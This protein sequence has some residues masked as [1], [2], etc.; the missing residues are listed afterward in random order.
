MRY[1][2]SKNE[3][4]IFW[5]GIIVGY[6]EDKEEERFHKRHIFKVLDESRKVYKVTINTRSNIRKRTL[7]KEGDYVLLSY[8]RHHDE[9]DNNK[10]ESIIEEVVMSINELEKYSDEEIREEYWR[11]RKLTTKKYSS[12]WH[13]WDARILEMVKLNV[14]YNKSCYK[15]AFRV[16]PMF[17]NNKLKGNE[18]FKVLA[19][20]KWKFKDYPKVGDIV[21]LRYKKHVIG[22]DYIDESKII[23]IKNQSYGR[24]S[25]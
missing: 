24:K 25:N 11:R 18:L 10:N 4:R 5:F 19:T 13:Y 23:C 12:E 9:F 22:L 6:E 8:Y 16:E 17:P 21:T 20:S 1:V 7:P 15:Y 14:S 3:R 2:N